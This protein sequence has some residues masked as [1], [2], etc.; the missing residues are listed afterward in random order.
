MEFFGSF[1]EF[2]RIGNFTITMYAF[3]IM[4]GAGLAA[5]IS[6]K[7]GKLLG[8]D[9][10]KIL[11]GIL[12]G[13]PLG[14]LGA[15]I[16]YVIFEW[17]RYHVSGDLWKTFKNII[18]ITEGG[19]AITGGIIVAVIYAFI[20]CK[21]RKINILKILDL[22]APGMLIAQACGRWGN[23]FNKEAYGGK[24][25]EGTYNWMSKI[26][27]NFI[28]ENMYINGAY[29][30]PTFLYEC[31]WNLAGLA[32]IVVSR[33]IWKKVQ[34]GDY[35]G[36]Y[37]IWYG[38]GRATLIEPFRT[39]ALMWGDIRVN[40]LIPALFAIGGIIYL[41]VKHLCFPQ[42]S[43]VLEKE[44]IA[45]NAPAIPESTSDKKESF[46]DI[47]IAKVKQFIEFD[48][49]GKEEIDYDE[50]HNRDVNNVKEE[51]NNQNIENIDE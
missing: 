41:F 51:D 38:I 33:K 22:L 19:L 13:L 12:F 43:Y 30:H 32:I 7:E 24:I 35:V 20:Y 2:L 36:F 48:N 1:S 10:N 49:D 27:P 45:L 39:D 11:D 15:R 6:V 29:R 23:F 9:T 37:L 50:I 3:C 34:I 40:I 16:Y 47:I 21:V 4:F 42:K 14:I 17:D 8:M 25:A 44:E 31:L 26:I 5:Y 28:M 46:K 18:D